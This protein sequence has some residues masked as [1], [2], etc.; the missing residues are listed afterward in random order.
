[1]TQTRCPTALRGSSWSTSKA[2]RSPVI[3]R[4]TTAPSSGGCSSFG[5]V[6]EAVQ[7]AHQHAV[8]HRDLKPSNIFVT[9]DGGVRLLDFGIAKQMEGFGAPV[10]QTR[11]VLRLMTPAYAAPEQVRGAQVGVQSDV[12]SL[13]IIL[14]ELLTGNLPFDFSNLTPAEAASVVVSHEAGKP[15]VVARRKESAVETLWP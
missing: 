3:A 7:Y 8:I 2:C 10:D 13:G 5:Q 4:S 11:T 6:C 1:M 9:K 14:Y 15:S 12:Y